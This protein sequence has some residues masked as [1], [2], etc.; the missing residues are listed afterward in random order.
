MWNFMKEQNRYGIIITTLL[1]LITLMINNFYSSSSTEKVNF[2]RVVKNVNDLNNLTDEFIAEA[3]SL[4][5]FTPSDS[6]FT[7][8]E[9][10]LDLKS[11]TSSFSVLNKKNFNNADS[12]KELKITENDKSQNLVL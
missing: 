6:K 11:Q 5:E 7:I 4:G 10:E 12:R 8:I 1:I 9:S 2:H 3:V